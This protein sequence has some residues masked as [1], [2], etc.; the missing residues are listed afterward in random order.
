MLTLKTFPS[1]VFLIGLGL[2]RGAGGTSARARG[3]R[4]TAV[5]GGEAGGQTRAAAQ[6]QPADFA[7]KCPGCWTSGQVVGPPVQSL[8]GGDPLRHA[9]QSDWTQEEP[10]ARSGATGLPPPH[11]PV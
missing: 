6:S 1:A 7:P 8:T 4:D 10:V 3:E 2:Q 11:S 5:V 9:G